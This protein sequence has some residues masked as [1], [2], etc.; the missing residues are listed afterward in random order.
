MSVSETSFEF[1]L[2][3]SYP[4]GHLSFVNQRTS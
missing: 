1:D 4:V 2:G 3:T